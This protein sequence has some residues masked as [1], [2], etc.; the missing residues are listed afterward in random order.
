MNRK[1]QNTLLTLVQNYFHSYLR[2]VRGASEHTVR[3]YGNALR[4][5]FLFL[6]QRT[7]HS[8][9]DLGLDHIQADAVLA[10]L[11]HI[12]SARSN[13]RATRNCRLAAIRSFVQHLLRNDISRADQYGRIMAIANK[14]SAPRAMCYLEPEEARAII[15]AVD[16]RT[17]YGARDRAL[18]LLLYNTGAR[19]SEALS[20]RPQELRLDRPRQVNLH[21]KGG[22]DRYCPLW[23]ETAVALRQILPSDSDNGVIFRNARGLPL[24]RDGAAYLIKKYV[25][26]ASKTIASLRARH[27]T[28]HIFRHSCAVALLQSGVDVTVIRDY[29]GHTSVSTTS[30]YITTNLK[31]K[32]DVLSAFWNRAGIEKRSP[33]PWHPSPKLLS[34]LESL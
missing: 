13:S 31:M 29:L 12:E 3:A 8:V 34:F 14:R 24:S 5:F 15:A 20:I 11:D 30:R 18:L 16:S 23:P 33:N 28:P 26:H 1:K 6:V 17:R 32:R 10:F 19:I 4:L 25:H 7:N 22:K 27:I 9:E 21:G 2:N